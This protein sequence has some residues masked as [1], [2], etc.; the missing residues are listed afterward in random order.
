MTIYSKTINDLRTVSLSPTPTDIYFTTDLGQEGN[1]RYDISDVDSPDNTGTV[2]VGVAGKRFKRIFNGYINVKWF[3]AKGNAWPNNVAPTDD[4]VAIQNAVTA[5]LTNWQHSPSFP[6]NQTLS[7]TSLKGGLYFPAGYY[8]TN[9]ITIP[10]TANADFFGKINII[11]AGI[12]ST[13]IV[14]KSRFRPAPSGTVTSSWAV[15]VKKPIITLNNNTIG[16]RDFAMIGT[17]NDGVYGYFENDGGPY[18][19]ISNSFEHIG[20][21]AELAPDCCYE[22]LYFSS[23][24]IG[25]KSSGG[26]LSSIKH[27]EFGGNSVQ[28][29]GSISTK[30]CEFG[31]W[32]DYYVAEDGIYAANQIYIFQTRFNYC[33]IWGIVF[34]NGTMLHI[35]SCEFMNNGSLIESIGDPST[36]AIKIIGYPS[37]PILED[38]PVNQVHIT[39]CWF[40]NNN[41]YDFFY[42]DYGNYIFNLKGCMFLGSGIDNRNYG[43]FINTNSLRS[44]KRI[45]NVIGCYCFISPNSGPIIGTFV[46]FCQEANLIGSSL[47]NLNVISPT[48][49]YNLEHLEL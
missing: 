24:H 48:T 8:L 17:H 18:F 14:G 2:I 29:Q 33:S 32:I 12:K 16:F 49:F 6:F 19:N 38:Y 41:G 22:K 39:G 5:L 40:E 10:I 21:N 47:Y 25:I 34:Q 1:W 3:G 45:V 30:I 20:L 15:P 44:H 23:C 4:T 31:L 13:F 36:G 43:T 37:E 7:L 42:S 11:G 46:I 9:E 35:D 26:L 27:C 28:V